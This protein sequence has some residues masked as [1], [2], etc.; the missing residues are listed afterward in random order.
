MEKRELPNST[1]ILIFG[2]LSI[3]G[4]CC[5][6]VAGVIFGIIALVMSKRA[7]EIYNADPELYTGYQNVKTGKILAIIGLVLSALSLLSTIIVFIFFGG[8]EG[9][10]EIQE[11]ILREYG[12]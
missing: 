10:Q 12:G 7:I 5:Y 11:E 2:I 8:M 4:C 6:G 1:L 3:I 9:M